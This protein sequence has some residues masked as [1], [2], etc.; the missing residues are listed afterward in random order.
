MFGFVIV[1]LIINAKVTTPYVA[2]GFVFISNISLCYDTFRKRFKAMKKIIFKY[3]KKKIKSLPNAEIIRKTLPERLFWDTCKDVLPIEQEIF[4]MLANMLII[5]SV[6]MLALAIIIFFGEVF[7]SSTL[8]E[9][10]A[11]LLS[12]KLTG[13]LFNGLITS[14]KFKGWEKME[15]SEKIKLSVDNYIKQFEG[16]ERAKA[17]I[18]TYV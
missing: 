3:H 16:I 7:N 10:G 13:I 9:A 2:F 8:V 4:A 15:K 14:A 11:V 12:G 18:I 6:S 5:S 17:T 1:G